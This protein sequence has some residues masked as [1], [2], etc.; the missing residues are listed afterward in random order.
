MDWCPGRD[1]N[2]HSLNGKRILSPPRLPF[3]HLGSWTVSTVYQCTTV[4]NY[5]SLS[6]ETAVARTH[7]P[8]TGRVGGI[9]R[10]RIN[11]SAESSER[12][13]RGAPPVPSFCAAP[14]STDHRNSAPELSSRC[15]EAANL[16]DPKSGA[17]RF[18]IKTLTRFPA[19][20]PAKAVAGFDDRLLLSLA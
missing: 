17:P 15:S 1:S 19:L 5:T 11:Q 6:H 20:A 13:D 18:G 16:D 14:R 8:P 4:D 7:K 2:P 12:L 9:R 10:S 3:R